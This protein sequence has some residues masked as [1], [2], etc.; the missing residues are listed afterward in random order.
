MMQRIA[1]DSMAQLAA[2]LTSP[3]VAPGTPESE[4]RMVVA[5]ARDSSPDAAGILRIFQPETAAAPDALPG[6]DTGTAPRPGQTAAL[7]A[8]EALAPDR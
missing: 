7:S 8:R 1:R 4:P 5:G 6:G 2:F 3:E